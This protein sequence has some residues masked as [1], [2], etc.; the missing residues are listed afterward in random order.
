MSILNQ[1]RALQSQTE[2]LVSNEAL[3]DSRTEQD[4][5]H[6]LTNFATLINFFDNHNEPYFDWAPALLK[7]PIFLLASISKN[8]FSEQ[9]RIELNAI[10]KNRTGNDVEKGI[11]QLCKQLIEGFMLLGSW[12]HYMTQTNK[13]YNLKKYV[14]S[15]VK[16]NFSA[17]LWS[18]LALRHQLFLSSQ[19]SGIKPIKNTIFK[20]YDEKVWKQSNGKQPYWEVLNI[21]HPVTE[22][23][24]ETILDAIV[25]VG[26]RLYTFMDQIVSYATHEFELLKKQKSQF[27]DTLLL[28]TF[29]NLLKV[30]QDQLNTLSAKHLQFYYSSI[31]N[32]IRYT[33]LN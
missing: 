23:S 15:E 22:N 31:L 19:L 33:R 25:N 16:T 26:N 6:F 18:L 24:N 13:E 21:K 27:P 2:T 32:K 29:V 30:Q 5:L 9:G 12:T 10:S 3:I 14:L 20:S 11:D 28:R 1:Y 8:K 17:D 7:D 4:R